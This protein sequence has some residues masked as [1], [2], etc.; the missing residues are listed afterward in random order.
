MLCLGWAATAQA[1]H[2]PD[3]E[4]VIDGEARCVEKGGISIDYTEDQG[5]KTA[6]MSSPKVRL[7]CGSNGQ[8]TRN[9][10]FA[11][12]MGKLRAFDRDCV[13]QGGEMRFK[14]ASFV[15][16]QNGEFCLEAQPDIGASAFEEPLCNY[17]SMCPAVT[18]V[19][20]FE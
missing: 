2:K 17:R 3:R 6:C 11:N 12:W 10:A 13:D 4:A 20:S 9:Q 5:I 1:A 18:V 19:C 8:T 14:E 7:L 15:E 16:P